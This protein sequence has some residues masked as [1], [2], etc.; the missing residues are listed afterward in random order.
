[1]LSSSILDAQNNTQ[2]KDYFSESS[3]RILSNNTKQ[4]I[5]WSAELAAFDSTKK[6][7]IGPV[8]DALMKE[9]K[10]DFTIACPSF[11]DAGRTVYNGHMFVKGDP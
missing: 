7:N 3:G 2:L 8:T 5:L 9:L 11:P 1:M 6:G 10:T 4:F